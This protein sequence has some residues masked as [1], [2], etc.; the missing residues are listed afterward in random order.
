MTGQAN[1]IE[2]TTLSLK[3]RGLPEDSYFEVVFADDTK[4]SEHEVNWSSIS[5]RRVVDVMNGKKGVMVCVFPVKRISACLGD[6]EA[7]IDVPEGNEAYQATRS[8]AVV[9]PGY[10]RQDRVVGRIIGIL[11]GDVV[12]EEKFLNAIEYRVQGIRTNV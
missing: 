11:K 9:I 8:E 6:L 3:E 7:S 10:G 4:I 12:V 1:T 2:R 5:A